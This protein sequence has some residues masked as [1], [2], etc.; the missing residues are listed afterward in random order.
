MNKEEMK[1]LIREVIN[2]MEAE[3][4]KKICA[5]WSM[6][7]QI[8]C[9]RAGV[10]QPTQYPNGDRK[11]LIDRPACYMTREEMCVTMHQLLKV[12]EARTPG[13][14]FLQEPK[15]PAHLKKEEEDG[16]VNA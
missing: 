11:D 7:A 13:E 6:N 10:M 16:G 2:E 9:I 8:E 4:A 12:V 5:P 3:R 14:K 1:A 15:V